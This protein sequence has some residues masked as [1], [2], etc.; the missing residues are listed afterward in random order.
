MSLIQTTDCHLFYANHELVTHAGSRNPATIL[1]RDL[2]FSRRIRDAYSKSLEKRGSKMAVKEIGAR[3]GTDEEDPSATVNYDFGDDLDGAVDLF[4]A[5][6]IFSR[7]AAA[8]TVDLQALIRR[9]LKGENPKSEKEIQVLVSEW[10]PGTST[11]VRKTP[12]Q[13]AQEAVEALS[14]DEKAALLESLMG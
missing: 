8:A 5:D 4:G 2:R 11:R 9:H 1:Q 10:K 3:A 14:D 7:F 13:K 6:V 12:Q